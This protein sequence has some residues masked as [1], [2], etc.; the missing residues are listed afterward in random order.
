[1]KLIII[2]IAL[3]FISPIIAQPTAQDLYQNSINL[4]VQ[5]NKDPTNSSELNKEALSQMNK[6][7]KLNPNN[8]DAWY[9][10]GNVVLRI[11]DNYTRAAEFYN[12][13]L[14][15]DPTYVKALENVAYSFWERG[16]RYLALEYLNKTLELN[17]NAARASSSKK[18][19]MEEIRREERKK[20]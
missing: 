2:L 6:S 9:Y 16:D 18:T 10:K 12:K 7:I 17:P 8:P 3:I 5:A 20:K 14:E 4:I 13:T 1:M 19:L 15:L 11:T